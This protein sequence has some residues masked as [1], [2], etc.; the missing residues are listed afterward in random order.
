MA[1][2]P[3]K[4]IVFVNTETGEKVRY[5]GK[6]S[7]LIPIE[8]SENESEEASGLP[9]AAETPSIKYCC[10]LCTYKT[11]TQTDL[12]THL[13]EDHFGRKHADREAVTVPEDTDDDDAVQ[14]PDEEEEEEEADI[15]FVDSQ[16]A[17]PLKCGFCSFMTTLDSEFN[18]HVE[19]HTI[20]RPYHCGH[21]SYAAFVRAHVRSHCQRLHPDKEVIIEEEVRAQPG[22]ATGKVSLDDP[23]LK[24]KTVVRMLNLDSLPNNEFEK[25]LED[26]NITS[27]SW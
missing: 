19:T 15:T 17:V 22:G 9:A 11:L 14:V 12:A 18:Q 2:H 21:C 6:R 13:K 5:E 7:T 8:D 24:A 27:I 20:S 10:H 23:K 3:S 1:S 25:M 4:P 26:A 16:P